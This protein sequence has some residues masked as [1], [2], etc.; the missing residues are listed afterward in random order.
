MASTKCFASTFTVWIV[1][2][3]GAFHTTVH[4]QTTEVPLEKLNAY[5]FTTHSIYVRAVGG[6]GEFRDTTSAQ[7]TGIGIAFANSVGD[8]AAA[9]ALNPHAVASGAAVSYVFAGYGSTRVT[10]AACWRDL[11]VEDEGPPPAYAEVE[12]NSTSYGYADWKIPDT[13]TGDTWIEATINLAGTGALDTPDTELVVVDCTSTGV[14]QVGNTYLEVTFLDEGGIKVN[15]TLM[16]LSGPQTIYNVIYPGPSVTF[17]ARQYMAPGVAFTT[18][19]DHV[20]PIIFDIHTEPDDSVSIGAGILGE[21]Y[22]E[23]TNLKAFVGSP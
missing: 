18:Y 1:L 14:V 6:N 2:F 5:S 8:P 19:S 15:G 7:G 16:D 11:W 23:S 3:A 22:I 20:L 10:K 13:Q 9:S 17:T 4:A 12:L 21:T